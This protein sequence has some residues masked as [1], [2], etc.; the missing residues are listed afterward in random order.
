MSEVMQ[1]VLNK[2]CEILGRVDDLPMYRAFTVN[3]QD[4][5]LSFVIDDDD[6]YA[7]DEYDMFYALPVYEVNDLGWTY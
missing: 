4:W 3:G 6:P 2:D 7:M 5:V 1:I